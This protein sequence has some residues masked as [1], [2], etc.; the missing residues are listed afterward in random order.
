MYKDQKTTKQTSINN[1][2]GTERTW[3]E[4]EV[5]TKR[6]KYTAEHEKP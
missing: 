1:G 3:K 6:E 2:R 5:L 4:K